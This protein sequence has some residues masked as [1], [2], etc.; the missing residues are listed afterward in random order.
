MIIAEATVS[1][2]NKKKVFF[3]RKEKYLYKKKK[4]KM[5]NWNEVKLVFRIK[6]KQNTK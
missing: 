4:N 6:T 1:N 2:N 5:C 3:S